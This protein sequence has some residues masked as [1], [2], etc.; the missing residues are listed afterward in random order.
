MYNTELY[1]FYAQESSSIYVDSS[2]LQGCGLSGCSSIYAHNSSIEW[3][4]LV[5][6]DSANATLTDLYTGLYPYWNL[7]LNE[8]VEGVGYNL[9]LEDTNVMWGWNLYCGDHSNVKVDPSAISW[10]QAWGQSTVSVCNSTVYW[11]YVWDSAAVSLHDSWLNEF[12][13]RFRDAQKVVLRNLNPGFIRYWNIHVNGTA[14]GVSYNITL[15][16]TWVRWAWD[17]T[18]SDQSNVAVYNSTLNSLYAYDYPSVSIY[19]STIDS[20]QCYSFRGV[21]FFEDAVLRWNWYISSSQFYVSG[22]IRFI[23]AWVNMVGNSV[24]TRNFNVVTLA[25]T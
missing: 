4:G 20:L 9:T 21:L 13:L 12:L 3:I 18:C 22:N 19:N 6:Y 25:I 16:D 17:I 5:F 7:H 1:A 15:A 2:T 14:Q 23:N 8:T 24:V 11:L 10:L